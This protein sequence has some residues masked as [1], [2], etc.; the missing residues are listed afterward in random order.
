MEIGGS[1]IYLNIAGKA[2]PYGLRDP[3][4]RDKRSPPRLCSHPGARRAGRD[5]GQSMPHMD[6]IGT[7]PLIS[8]AYPDARIYM[9]AMSADLTRVLLYDSLEDHELP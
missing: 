3:A 2:D 4:V 8:K 9:T 7:L 1:C 5:P 6:H